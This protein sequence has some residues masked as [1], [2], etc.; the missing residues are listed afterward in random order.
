MAEDDLVKK[1]DLALSDLMQSGGQLTERE[2][3]RFAFTLMEGRDEYLRERID[4]HLARAAMHTRNKDYTWAVG[5]RKKALKWSRR[6]SDYLEAKIKYEPHPIQHL[7]ADRM[8][9]DLEDLLL[10]GDGTQGPP[11]GLDALFATG[12]PIPAE[13]QHKGLLN[14][15]KGSSKIGFG[16]R[17]LRAAKDIKGRR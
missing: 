7:I 15:I 9:E 13:T 5:S 6:L 10:N 4:H 1:A 3:H 17:I 12:A 14:A 8:A 16:Q 11:F 2:A